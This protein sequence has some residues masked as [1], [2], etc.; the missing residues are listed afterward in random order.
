[1]CLTVSVW[2]R[3]GVPE[4]TIR[5]PP[6]QDMDLDFDLRSAGLN[7]QDLLKW[8]W[9]CATGVYH[10]AGNTLSVEVLNELGKRNEGA[11][12]FL[13]KRSNVRV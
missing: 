11:E 5:C 4:G 6:G 8:R 2:Y 10:A 9:L 13:C 7:P 3:Y 1:M 12:E